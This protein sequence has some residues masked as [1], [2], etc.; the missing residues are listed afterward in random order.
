MAPMPTTKGEARSTCQRVIPKFRRRAKAHQ[1]MP[2]K[3]N[4]HRCTRQGTTDNDPLSK[5]AY[6]VT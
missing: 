2:K 5:E 3:I 6:D 1:R 4:Y